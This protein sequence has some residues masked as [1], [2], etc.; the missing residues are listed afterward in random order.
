MYL[1]AFCKHA[2]FYSRFITKTIKIMKLTTVLL[3][4]AC[5]QVSANGFSQKVT[6]N[7]SNIS[8]KR[9]FEIVRQQTGYQFFYADET[10][11]DAKRVSLNVQRQSIKEVLDLCFKDQQ[12]DYTITENTIIVKRKPNMAPEVLPIPP[13]PPLMAEVKGTVTDDKG[14]PLEGA[15]VLIKNKPGGVKTNASGNFSIDVEPNA[16]LVISYVG[17][18]TVEVRPGTKTVLSISLKPTISSGEQVIVVGYGTAKKKELTT[19]ISSISAATVEKLSI[20]RIEQ[21]LQG[22][23]AGVLILNQNGQP[24]DKPMIRIRGTGTNNSPDPLFLVDG[25]PV[26]SIEYLNPSDIE[27]IDVLKD[28]A[29]AA[30]YG[31]RGANGVILITTKQG[32]RTGS[33]LSYDGYVGWQTAWK[34][35]DVLNASEYATLMNES[36]YNLNPTGTTPPYANPAALGVG[37]NWQDLL[38]NKNA[39]V[40]SHQ[41][42]ASGGNEKSNYLASFAYFDQQGIIG[43]DN[44]KFKRYSLRLNM[45]QK[46]SSFL[47]LGTNMVFVHSD[48]N[49]IF[50]NGDQ[51]GSV[52]GHA[53]N[54]DPITPLYET[55]PTKLASYN[56]NA[57]KNGSN[58]YG[59]SPLATYPNPLAQMQI[60]NGNN[61]IDKLF[62]NV[63]GEV[64][65]YKG[66]KFK[67]SYG[68][69]LSNN[70]S[71]QLTPI[72]FLLS[73]SGQTFSTVRKSMSRSLTWQT[74]N[75][76]SYSKSIK[77]KHNVEALVGQ[78][79]FKFFTENLNGQRNDPSPVDPYLWYLDVATDIASTQA[80]GGADV[81]TMASYFGRV[82]YN[83]NGKYF[84]SGVIR[85]DGSSRFGRNNPYATF[86]SAS[87]AWLISKE[88][89]FK[90]NMV[91]LLKLRASWGQNGNENLGSSFPWASTIN[92]NGQQYTFLNSG[93]VEYFQ[94]GASL[95]RISNPFLKWET[96]EQTNIGV[97]AELWK[98]K[99]SITADYY[100]K[101]TKDLLIAPD[102]PL[103]VGF[104][105]PFVNGGSV[106]NKG[107][108][109]SL[110]YRGKIA[111][112]LSTNVSFNISTNK[113]KVTGIN[114]S[115]KVIGG[116]SYINMGSIT[117]MTVGEPIGYFW[118]QVTGGIFQSQA[119]VDAYTWTNP[120]TSVV[121]KIQPNAKAGDL[122]FL[123]NNNDGRINDLDR[124]NIGDP[125]PKYVTGLTINLEYKNFDFSI[126]T[127]GMFGHKVFNG[128]Y[129]FD[130]AIS[131]LPAKY[132]DRWTPSNT[133]T[134]IPRFVAGSPNFSTVSDFY[135]E[136]GNFIRAK[137]IQIGYSLPQAWISR[138]K[139]S[140]L[141]FYIAVDNA[142]TITKYSG[143]D[144]EIGATSP[145][146]MGIDRGVYP[147]SRA[148]RLGVNL[149]L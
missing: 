22:N 88:N 3:I 13:P 102:V 21:A 47:K 60:L 85:R 24:G 144:P 30:I 124:V 95:G 58:I 92:F 79:A 145:L 12:L 128:N 142:F 44:S 32:K 118:G 115:S 99:L 147:Q 43:G 80:S 6:I 141:R 37:T 35:V 75:V 116:A 94:S 78:S 16:V 136:S 148:F 29:S 81:R 64:N 112:K 9:V 19:A 28:A 15:T 122:K 66:L 109:L 84:L 130:K 83:Y 138:A 77:G 96:S 2:F 39:P 146:S 31:A 8:L 65:L 120:T 97:D 40:Q 149:K 5:L 11:A 46:V 54:I 107:V 140:S 41:V 74:E 14:Q 18:E 132:L 137:N 129:R 86:P 103:I 134:D 61:K 4:A 139:L 59:I 126:L 69:D 67:S 101:K 119:E 17:F 87:A 82:A 53:L 10:L 57:V 52:V 131:N 51:G 133:N 25:F 23:A 106:E 72:Y 110:N 36:Y 98:G 33:S 100:I 71:N 55:D 26:G 7:E 49:A 27:R 91:N 73:G 63:Y 127:I 111:N 38:F 48:R 50:D 76:L 68:I 113:N 90:S 135:L 108:E 42:T 34:K 117:R 20:T 56:V 45:D 70:T 114:N 62:G 93:G 143:F 1:T 104:L 123:D 105:A 121:N 125:N 89:F